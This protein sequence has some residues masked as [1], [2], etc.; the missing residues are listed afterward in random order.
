MVVGCEHCRNGFSRTSVLY[1]HQRTAKYCMVLQ[2]K[3]AETNSAPVNLTCRY[4]RKKFTRKD[5]VK[6]HEKTCSEQENRTT[7]DTQLLEMIVQLQK[8]IVNMADRPIGPTN[9]N[10]T[11]RNVTM[12]LAPITDQELQE[13]L[14]HLTIE[15]I[16]EGGKGYA[17]WANSYPFKDR[18]VCT[19]KAR[20]KLRYKDNEGEIIEDGGG[21]KLTQRFFQ[22]IAQR[23]EEIINAEYRALHEEVQRIAQSGTAHDADLTGLL[24]KASHLQD[25]LIK[26]RNAARGEEN[27]LTKEFVNHLSKML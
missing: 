20:K 24:T 11:N 3:I 16:Q 19:D 27:E 6:R 2:G 13:H 9:V 23:N 15:F 17:D 22:A 1:K 14:Q 4:C 21:I 5:V 12:N 10:N 8:T 7:Q 25:L 26:C 18:V